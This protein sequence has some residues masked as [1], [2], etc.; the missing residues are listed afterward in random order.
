MDIAR[1]VRRAVRDIRKVVPEF[2]IA[3]DAIVVIPAQIDTPEASRNDFIQYFKV[4][5]NGRVLLATAWSWFAL[6]VRF[7][8]FRH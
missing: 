8:H 5:R 7:T 3:D 6:G 4:W 2:W 1:N